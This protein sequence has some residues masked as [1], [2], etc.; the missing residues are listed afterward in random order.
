MRDPVGV[1]LLFSTP[2]VE[3]GNKF[4][5][6]EVASHKELFFTILGV[7]PIPETTQVEWVDVVSVLAVP[8]SVFVLAFL[9]IFGVCWQFIGKKLTTVWAKIGLACGVF[10]LTFVAIVIF[11]FVWLWRP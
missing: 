10:I 1:E 2:N 3:K 9:L 5:A 11:L 4:R 8:L 6:T 7:E